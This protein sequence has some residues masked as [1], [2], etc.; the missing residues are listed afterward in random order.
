LRGPR[1]AWAWAE[2]SVKEVAWNSRELKLSGSL[3]VVRIAEAEKHRAEWNE[4]PYAPPEAH[5]ERSRDDQSPAYQGA[6][7]PDAEKNERL[8]WS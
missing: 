7:D 1:K 6:K 2:Q 4:D 5:P 3:D 8:H